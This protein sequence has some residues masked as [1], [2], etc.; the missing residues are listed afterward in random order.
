[1]SAGHVNHSIFWT[2]LA[3]ISKNGG[4][5]P[6]GRQAVPDA[7]HEAECLSFECRRAAECHQQGPLHCDAL[8]HSVRLTFMQEWGSLDNFV[9]KFNASTAAVQGSGWGWLVRLF[10]RA[11]S[12]IKYDG[13]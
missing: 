9:Q 7:F 10:C 3:P 11:L 13:V 2:N 6:K 5:P 4:E 8:V 12:G 1:M